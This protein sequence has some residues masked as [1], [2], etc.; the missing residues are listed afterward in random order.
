MAKKKE[1]LTTEQPVNVTP[2]PV[3][4]EP[5]EE[6]KTETESIPVQVEPSKPKG[7]LYYVFCLNVKECGWGA[8]K[9]VTNAGEEKCPKC[10]NE[11]GCTAPKAGLPIE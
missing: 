2:E 7:V 1:E 5:K 3:T 4:E 10:K 11:V 6:P 8:N 9:Y